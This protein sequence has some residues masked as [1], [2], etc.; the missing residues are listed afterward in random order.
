VVEQP[1]SCAWPHGSQID[2]DLVEQPRVQALLDR[3]G[4]WRTLGAE[5]P[6]SRNSTGPI[7]A[8]VVTTAEATATVT[9]KTRADG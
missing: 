8:A 5:L 6:S 2:V 9:I 1:H 3:L 4:A 7:S